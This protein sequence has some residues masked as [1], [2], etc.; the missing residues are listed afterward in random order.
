MNRLILILALV[1]GFSKS[2]GQSSPWILGGKIGF[3]TS[4]IN[5]SEYEIP[6][7]YRDFSRGASFAFGIRGGYRFF[8][9][10]ALNVDVEW[11]HLRDNQKRTNSFRSAN[12][13]WVTNTLQYEAN[14]QRLQMPVTLQFSPL[15]KAEFRP[16]IVVG[17]VPTYILSGSFME[18]GRSSVEGVIFPDVDLDADFSIPQNRKY[19]SASHFVAGLGLGIG[20]HFAIEALHHFGEKLVYTTFDPGNT[21]VLP[22]TRI[23]Y[24]QRISQLSLIYLI[25]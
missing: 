6:E 1:T 10:F 12:E 16:Y 3:G 18:K 15:K 2:Y 9:Y 14:L 13:D 4:G 17:I 7:I 25:R 22:P 24:A 5:K 8:R 11:Q 23:T 20:K 21:F 19:K